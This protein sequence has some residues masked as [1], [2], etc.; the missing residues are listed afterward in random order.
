MRPAARLHPDRLVVHRPVHE[1]AITGFLQEVGRDGRVR[2][3]GAHPAG[4]PLAL[5]LLD[6]RGHALDQGA[7]IGLVEMVLFVRVG[8]AMA[9][10]LVA[11]RA[12]LLGDVGRHLV[13]RRVHLRL[14]RDVERVEHFEQAPHADPV[15]V[16]AP[17]KD[18]MAL[19]LIG[20]RDRRALALAEGERLDVERDI[21]RETL[22][23][24]PVVIGP[25]GNVGILVAAMC[26]QHA[27]PS[28]MNRSRPGT[29]RRF[30]DK[31]RSPRDARN[32]RC[33]RRPPGAN[34]RCLGGWS[35]RRP[36]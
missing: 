33:S 19:R 2:Q 14:D 3:P 35:P 9:K 11:P 1:V 10:K 25:R 13:D 22:A 34:R 8:L 18:R 36:A 31:P 21:N 32:A 6:G 4:R 29:R 17:R 23:I 7:L 30:R 15:A 16:V 27:A 28:P 20:R 26:R 5:V 24:G 12:Q